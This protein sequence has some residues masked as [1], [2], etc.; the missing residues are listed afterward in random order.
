MSPESLK[1]RV[2]GQ[3]DL[4][5]HPSSRSAQ[6]DHVL[7]FGVF[8]PRI[9]ALGVSGLAEPKNFGSLEPKS[10]SNTLSLSSTCTP[11]V[12]RMIACWAVLKCLGLI[13]HLPVGFRQTLN[14]PYLAHP[15]SSQGQYGLL[16]GPQWPLIVLRV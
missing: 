9:R 13:F 5:L 3:N 16:N 11:T 4:R 7:I 15:Y 2:K 12:C 6:D 10:T 14:P 1:N 8:A